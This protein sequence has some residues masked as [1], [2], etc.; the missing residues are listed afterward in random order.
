MYFMLQNKIF[1]L[2]NRIE[3]FATNIIKNSRIKNSEIVIK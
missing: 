2:S 1:S 3:S